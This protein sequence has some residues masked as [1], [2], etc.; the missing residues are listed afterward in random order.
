M[1]IL[2]YALNRSDKQ[3]I[4]GQ[5]HTKSVKHYQPWQDQSTRVS[6]ICCSYISSFWH[7]TGTNYIWTL[8]FQTSINL[9]QKITYM[10]TR[11]HLYFQALS[12]ALIPL[13]VQLFSR[14]LKSLAV[15]WWWLQS[16]VVSWWNTPTCISQGKCISLSCDKH[17]TSKYTL[18]TGVISMV[19]FRHESLWHFRID[20][21]F[22]FLETLWVDIL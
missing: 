10:Q 17:L 19:L 15:F 13:H 5:G 11:L 8:I 22:K 14:H 1:Q 2:G 9:R 12:F 20:R 3:L 18:F 6:L 16:P 21:R 4:R 7:E